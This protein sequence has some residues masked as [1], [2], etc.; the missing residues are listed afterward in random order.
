MFDV[1][2]AS[3]LNPSRLIDEY[4]QVTGNAHKQLHRMQVVHGMAA[5]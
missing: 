5:R 4:P 2:G 3:S 1:L